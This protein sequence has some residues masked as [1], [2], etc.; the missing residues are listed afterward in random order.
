MSFGAGLEAKVADYIAAIDDSGGIEPLVKSNGDFVEGYNQITGLTA[1]FVRADRLEEFNSRWNGLR[2]RIQ[3]EL[4]C[5]APPAIHM[6]L[7]WGKDL[8]KMHRRKPNPYVDATFDQIKGWIGAALEIIFDMN[9]D[10]R[11]LNYYPLSAVRSEAAERLTRYFSDPFHRAEMEFIKAHSRGSYKK[12]YQHYHNRLAS[13]LLPLLTTLLRMLNEAMLTV[14]RTIAIDIDQ[15]GDSHG[16]DAVEVYKVI[17]SVSELQQIASVRRVTDADETPLSQAADV[18]SYL[19]FRAQSI[20]KGFTKWD[21]DLAELVNP[22]T[23]RLRA[24]TSANLKHRI[25]RR[26][27]AAVKDYCIHY[28]LARKQIV[29]D[30]PKFAEAHLVS[31]EEFLKRAIEASREPR[32]GGISVLK[33]WTVC[34]TYY[35]KLVND[36]DRG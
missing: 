17:S 14:R 10:P 25:T 6:R 7:M 27:N 35:D 22:Y 9:R 4:G 30:H 8:K 16:I 36:E 20:S 33:D 31:V 19:N 32:S 5:D 26:E 2:E 21:A 15:F 18:I 24:F 11:A 12:M 1:V 28:A 13:P 29:N 3:K 34:R 23:D